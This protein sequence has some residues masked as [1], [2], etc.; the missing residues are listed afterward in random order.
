MRTRPGSPSQHDALAQ[1]HVLAVDHPGQIVEVRN[2]WFDDES[3]LV[4]P[5]SLSMEHIE[6]PGSVLEL[7]NVEDFLVGFTTTFP[8]MP[9]LVEVE[10]ERWLGLVHTLAGSRWSDSGMR[11]CTYLDPDREW[12]PQSAVQGSIERIWTFLNDAANGRFNASEALFHPIG[13]IQLYAH[14]AGTAVVRRDLGNLDK[15]LAIGSATLRSPARVDMG[16]RDDTTLRTITISVPAPLYRGPGPTLQTLLYQIAASGGATTGAAIGALQ[17]AAQ[18]NGSTQPLFVTIAVSRSAAGAGDGHHLAVARIDQRA[19]AALAGD[20]SQRG[21]LEEPVPLEWLRTADQRNGTATRRDAKRPAGHLRGLRVE[22]WGCGA[23]GSWIAEF[24]VRAGVAKII[25]SDPAVVGADL[26]VRQNYTEADVGFAKAERLAERLNA[27]SDDVIAR[28]SGRAQSRLSES[29]PNCD[30]VVD[31]TVSESVGEALNR[32]AGE[33][34]GPLLV[35]VSTDVATASLG[36][37]AVA[38]PSTK[39]GPAGIDEALY[40]CV[41]RDGELETFHAFWRDP[42]PGEELVAM[43][44]CSAPTFHGS[45]ADAAGMAAAMVNTIAIHIGSESSGLHL[46]AMPYADTDSPRARYIPYNP[47]G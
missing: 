47:S 15:K 2:S 19:V 40:D 13:G 8:D 46:L 14:N 30:L 16:R 10:H 25:V 4:V 17:R 20:P 6:H 11:L 38:A 23:L 37:V 36:L 33:D 27:I 29:L 12:H 5:V 21:A 43:K 45:A 3:T 41:L 1:L 28:P 26:L 22:V 7:S 39:M 31:A 9:A 35:A 18:H 32:A 24:F 34:S 44:G 42:L